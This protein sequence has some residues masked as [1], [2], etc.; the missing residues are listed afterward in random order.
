MFLACSRMLS[1]FTAPLLTITNTS[2]N[3]F[4][5]TNTFPSTVGSGLALESVVSHIWWKCTVGLQTIVGGD[6]KTRKAGNPIQATQTAR[7]TEMPQP[8]VN[9]NK[10]SLMGMQATPSFLPN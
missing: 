5:F 8:Q 10:S 1:L 9:I 4:T 6:K 2:H 3:A 7:T